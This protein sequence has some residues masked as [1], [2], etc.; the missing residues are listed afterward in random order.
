MKFE[1]KI[2]IDELTYPQAIRALLPYITNEDLHSRYGKKRR[3]DP[4][5]A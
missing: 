4:G 2:D 3:R 1:L 5:S